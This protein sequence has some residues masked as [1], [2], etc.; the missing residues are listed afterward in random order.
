MEQAQDSLRRSDGEYSKE[1]NSS[2]VV[3]VI[4]V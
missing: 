3:V 1:N 4:R 2:L